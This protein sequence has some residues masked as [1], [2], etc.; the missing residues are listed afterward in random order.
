[1]IGA[2]SSGN[3]SSSEALPSRR[4]T[5]ATPGRTTVIRSGLRIKGELTGAETLELA[6]DF[7]GP[8]RVDGLCHLLETGRIEGP[9]T[10]G[11]AVIEGELKGSLTVRGKV[12]LRATASVRGDISA[13]SVAL[14]EGCYFE[15]HI[16]MEAGE[17][18]EPRSFQEKRRPR[19]TD[20]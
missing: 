19:S 12:E 11:D 2:M 9:V 4:F 6:G 16:H 13:A 20:A 7:D 3:P 5:D 14:A 18:G 15:G 17:G 10:A 1:M 8:L